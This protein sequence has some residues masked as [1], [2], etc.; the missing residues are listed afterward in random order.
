MTVTHHSAASCVW[1]LLFIGLTTI[2]LLNGCRNPAQSSL[3][4]GAI[5]DTM[6]PLPPLPKGDI[7]QMKQC[8]RP[9]PRSM[10]EIRWMSSFDGEARRGEIHQRGPG[11]GPGVPGICREINVAGMTA[12]QAE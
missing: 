7:S 9:K 5:A 6:P 8:R 12:A 3:P 11:I 2:P 4:P 1:L 10:S